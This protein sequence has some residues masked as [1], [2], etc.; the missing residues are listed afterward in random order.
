MKSFKQYILSESKKELYDKLKKTFNGM[1]PSQIV[2]YDGWDELAFDIKMDEP[3]TIP[4][5]DLKVK[6]KADMENTKSDMK[7][8]FN[9]KPLSELPPI[10]VSYE[11]GNY[12]IE[13]GHHRYAYA[14]QQNIPKVEVIVTDIKDNPITALGFDRIDDVINLVKDDE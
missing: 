10:E 4:T 13:D 1:T 11:K 9:D 8:Y 5:K 14:K 7:E 12:Y 2:T 3:M 6:Y